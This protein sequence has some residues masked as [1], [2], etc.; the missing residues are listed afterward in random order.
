MKVVQK[1]KESLMAMQKEYRISQRWIEHFLLLFQ[2]IEHNQT[3]IDRKK[4]LMDEYGITEQN[5]ADNM[6][7]DINEA[8]QQ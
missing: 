2:E 6:P 8:Q 5:I 4:D 7:M 1:L 3:D